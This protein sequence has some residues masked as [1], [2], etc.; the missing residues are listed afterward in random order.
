M[1][2]NKKLD[3]SIV[4]MALEDFKNDQNNEEVFRI[5]NQIQIIKEQQ[6][7][8]KCFN[9]ETNIIDTIAYTKA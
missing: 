4:F 1:S 7:I 9:E 3:Y 5:I 6:E 2:E 8:I